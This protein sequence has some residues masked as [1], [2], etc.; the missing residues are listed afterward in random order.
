[1]NK[2]LL[3]KILF[4]ANLTISILLITFLIV[5]KPSG[6]TLILTILMTFIGLLGALAMFK[7]IRR[8]PKADN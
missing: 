2:L 1:M 5:F 8:N 7:E 3:Y 6:K 4:T